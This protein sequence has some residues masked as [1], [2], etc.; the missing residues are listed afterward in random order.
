MP[1]NTK[2]FW[3]D[4]EHEDDNPQDFMNGV[5]RSFFGKSSL[6][7]ADKL[8]QFR[9]NLKAGS[10]AMAWLNGLAAT[11]KDTW[12][13]LQASFVGRWPEKAP[14]MK[15]HMERIALLKAAKLTD[16]EMGK[17]VKVDGMEEFS[18]IVWADKIERLADAVPD[19]IGLLISSIREDMPAVLKHYV[20]EHATW[21]A[22]CDAIRAV[23]PTEIE[24]QQAKE[25]AAKQL[26][27]DVRI[28]K[29]RGTPLKALGNAFRNI[30]L[31]AP[32]PAPRFNI[33]PRGFTPPQPTYP[34]QQPT[35]P[36]QQRMPTFQ[37]RAD[38]DRMN[39]VTRLALPIHPDTPAGRLAYNTQITTWTLANPNGKVNEYQPYPLTP[40]TAPAASRECW[41][42][43]YPGH[44]SQACNGTRLPALETTWRSIAATIRRN[45][46]RS[47][48]AANVNYVAFEDGWASKEE[49]DQQVISD[50]LANQGKAE[51][52]ST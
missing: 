22:F 24:E 29:E 52:S 12:E 8:K 20:K 9:L 6:T 7:D 27:E 42:C 21:T 36:P 18:H 40:G 44:M 28:I 13:H 49:Y 23:S 30:N 51:G 50:Y 43:G 35:Y 4:G 15:S 16:A 31:G 2:L 47:S 46:D 39:D 5:E 26:A 19:T 10:V 48:T 25:K 45:H 33:P 1:E 32:I 17:R 34:L 38:A 37:P 11:K 41:T 3:G 14:P